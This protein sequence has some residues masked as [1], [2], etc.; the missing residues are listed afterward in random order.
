MNTSISELV[1]AI[2]AGM[3][4]GGAIIAALAA[5]LGKVWADRMSQTQRLIGEIDL[6]LRKRRIDAY[7]PLWKATALL[8]KWPRNDEATYEQLATLSHTLRCWYYETGGMY[9]SRT[10]RDLGYG[11]LQGTIATVI[12]GG[13]S[14]RIEASDY[15]AVRKKCSELR[16]LMTEDIESRRESPI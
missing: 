1:L 16:T 6:D 9:L 7:Q 4:G 15:E 3:G 10:A 11:P 8:P 12:A 5:W 14:G 13:K 2:L